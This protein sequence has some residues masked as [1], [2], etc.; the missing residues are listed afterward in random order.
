[1]PAVWSLE[2]EARFEASCRS[3]G[4]DEDS[5][6]CVRTELEKRFSESQV[7]AMVAVLGRGDPLAEPVERQLREA[8]HA[9][10]A[11]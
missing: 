7:D 10:G 6:R 3:T 11:G 1:V 2:A 8:E 9:C 4:G 5:C